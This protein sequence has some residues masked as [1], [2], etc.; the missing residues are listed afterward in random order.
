MSSS[1]LLILL[2]FALGEPGASDCACESIDVSG[3]AVSATVTD[4][5]LLRGMFPPSIPSRVTES[6][7][8]RLSLCYRRGSSQV[9]TG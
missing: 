1:C 7:Q 3:P 9:N 4:A 6:W 5:V 2:R 8:V